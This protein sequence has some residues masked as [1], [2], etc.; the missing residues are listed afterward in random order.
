MKFTKNMT[1]IKML[2]KAC[3]MIPSGAIHFWRE[4]KQFIFIVTK[5]I[6]SLV[7]SLGHR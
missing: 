7:T 4:Q 5:K 1:V 2:T 3:A 6:I